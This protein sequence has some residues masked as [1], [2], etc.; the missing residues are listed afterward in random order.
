MHRQAYPQIS[1][2]SVYPHTAPAV[3]QAV[4]A[5]NSGIESEMTPSPSPIG[6]PRYNASQ[7]YP[8]SSSSSTSPQLPPL[9]YHLSQVVEQPLKP[10][11]PS[12]GIIPINHYQMYPTTQ[13]LH[14][15]YHQQYYTPHAQDHVA[16]VIQN[17]PIIKSQSAAQPHQSDA[18]PQ[19]HNQTNYPTS[20]TLSTSYHIPPPP[21]PPRK[22]GRKSKQDLLLNRVALTAEEKKVNHMH[23]E[24]RRRALVRAA[25]ANLASL[26]PGMKPPIEGDGSNVG[27]SDGSSRV[28]ILEG[29][30]GMLMAL[31]AR[32]VLLKARLDRPVPSSAL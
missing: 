24:Q 32:N 4:T 21:N 26:I 16:S 18:I 8:S 30:S 14:H 6:S 12:N 2:P 20:T 11:V 5:T 22:R 3:K 10:Q 28:E 7:S 15:N 27:L 17:A 23:A 13:Q 29:A 31:K 1:L 25:L 9:R 19:P